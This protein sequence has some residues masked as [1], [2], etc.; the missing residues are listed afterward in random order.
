VIIYFDTSALVK[1]YVAEAGSEVAL[2]LW[3]SATE[4]AASQILYAEMT[5]TFARKRREQPGSAVLLDQAQQAFRDDW[6][7]I[8]RI[9]VDD[10]VNRRVDVL[11]SQHPLRG[12]DSI[13]LASALL[14]RDLVQDQVTFACADIA[15]VTTQRPGPE[16]PSSLR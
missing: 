10:A 11:L 4:L 3:A 8:H 7:G 13:H 9:P 5:A 12:A 2:T 6:E 16:A 1:R 14:L 15:L